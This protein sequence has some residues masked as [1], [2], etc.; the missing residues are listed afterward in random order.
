MTRNFSCTILILSLSLITSVLSG[1]DRGIN[2]DKYKIK[3]VKSDSEI[4]IDGILDDQVWRSA[5]KAVSF[6][7]VEPTDTGFAKAQTEVQVSYDSKT[8]FF[9]ITCFDPTPG[10]RPVESLRP[11]FTFYK[12]DNFLLFMDTFND[13]TNGFSFGITA[14]GSIWDGVQANGAAVNLNWDTKWRSAVK[15]YD[16]RWTAEFAIPFRS[17]RY[18]GGTR[19][20]GINFSRLDLKINEKSSWAPMPRQFAT[21][22]L[23]YTGTLEWDQPL[24][25]SGPRI[26]FIPY[27]SLKLTRN[28]Q[29]GAE[30][31]IK[32]NAGAD[33][34]VILSTSMNLDIT[35]NPDYS[36]VE[37]DRQ[38]TNL[39]RFELF[40]P[41][42]R[43]FYLE[44]SDLF[45]NLGSE[46]VRPF[47][48]RRIGLN[49]PVYAGARLSGKIGDDWRIGLMDVQT[50]ENGDIP[51][52]NFAV[53]SIQKKV[54]SHS[55]ITAFF[56]D[57]ERTGS[58]DDTTMTGKVFNRVAGL[59]YNLASTG[60][61][62]TGKAYYHHSFYS[63][64]ENN[65]AAAAG[66]TYSSKYY[67]LSLNQAMVGA[68]YVSDA[69][70]IR[71][72]GYYQ[73][74]PVLQYKFYTKTGTLVYHGPGFRGDI[75]FDP[76]FKMSDRDVQL[77]YY[78]VWNNRSTLT[79]DAKDSYVR[80]LAPFDP[81]NTGGDS[82]AAG[83][84]FDWK[85]AGVS[86]G[87]DTRKLFNFIASCRYGGYYNG[88]RLSLA[89]EFYYRLQP[90]ASI[91]LV[92]SYNKIELPQP[93]N[94]TGLFLIGPRIDITF[95]NK[96]FFTSFIQYNSQID[97]LNLNFRFQW[98]YAPVS[99]LFI[100]YT[101]NAFP[102]NYLVKNRGL[103]VKLS[104]WFN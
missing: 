96:I 69:G 102:G 71:R 14:A 13:Q 89:G 77:L 51:A 78:F 25:K 43:Q 93:Y 36:Q 97:N 33:A 54:F 39:D 88:T 87:S 83:D 98:R 50:G 62:W 26:S 66:L 86:F 104:Y 101:E 27:G 7:R 42:K 9:A 2:R 12:N 35:V 90:Y 44:N 38:Q 85:E 31:V 63:G 1:Q 99:D 28:Y 22:T 73:I 67:T 72:N 23:A 70:Y 30:S 4:K 5:G 37:V 53:A 15:N 103:V 56:I 18:P 68:G 48:S 10:K 76:S 49:N 80:L 79:F 100:V 40:F 29:E 59:E 61:K 47:F 21:A 94:S 55:N 19:E 11:D 20:W 32:A 74:N 60:N 17:I 81:T 95:T 82:L 64:A 46:N 58:R 65:N 45:A 52:A 75:L 6:Q 84:E 16:D 34:K 24:P 92:S 41:E 8:I 3:T 91:A 57:R